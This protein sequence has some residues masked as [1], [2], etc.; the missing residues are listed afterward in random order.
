MTYKACLQ[1][2][3]LQMLKQTSRRGNDVMPL[4]LSIEE[5]GH[6][7]QCQQGDG[8]SAM[9]LMKAREIK[10]GSLMLLTRNATK[11]SSDPLVPRAGGGWRAPV[12]QTEST[13]QH[14]R[15]RETRYCQRVKTPPACHSATTHTHTHT[16]THSDVKGMAEGAMQVPLCSS[17]APLSTDMPSNSGP[18]RNHGQAGCFTP[19]LRSLC[20]AYCRGPTLKCKKC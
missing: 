7:E 20:R 8:R 6:P 14:T 15:L 2:S 11:P 17:S 5:T 19:Y 3:P 16:H 12:Q 4:R 1:D 18:G 10:R 13:L 9:S